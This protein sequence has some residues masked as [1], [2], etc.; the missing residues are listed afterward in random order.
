MRETFRPI[1]VHMV[2]SRRGGG[3][4]MLGR[5]VSWEAMHGLF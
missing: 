4:D 2:K 3:S 1:E 5:M